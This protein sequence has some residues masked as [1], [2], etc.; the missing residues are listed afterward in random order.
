MLAM[1][2][3]PL[4]WYS[5]GDDLSGLA[6]EDSLLIAK[7]LPAYS[8]AL[9]GGTPPGER[10]ELLGMIETFQQAR[11]A[12]MLPSPARISAEIFYNRADIFRT[13]F[14]AYLLLGFLLLVV[15]TNSNTRRKK[16]SCKPRVSADAGFRACLPC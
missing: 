9:A 3:T 1:F 7:I 4:R 14:R 6:R 5:P 2:P 11:G 8:A 10:A 15:A 16:R 13:A 12:G